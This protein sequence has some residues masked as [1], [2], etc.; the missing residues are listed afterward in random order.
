MDDREILARI[1][2]LMD[3]EHALENEA[4]RHGGLDD[5]EQGRLDELG[6]QLDQAWDLLR[7]R[8]A[9]RRAGEDPDGAVVRTEGTVEGYQQ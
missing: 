8:R 4:S 1:G 5:D 2:E 3:A 9:R 6:V 7:Q